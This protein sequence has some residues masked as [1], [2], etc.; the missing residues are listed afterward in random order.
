MILNDY[1]WLS[2]PYQQLASGIIHKRAHH[3]LLINY[4][5]GSG[6]D[7]FVSKLA[8]RL[9]CQYS[10]Q[11]EPCL[12]CHS[13]QLFLSYHH[14]DYYV[15][16]NEQG[17]QS[18]GIDQIRN[19]SSK[20]YEKSQQGGNK[21]LWIK[22]AALMTEAAANA[23]LKTLE[24]PP[25]NTYFILSDDHNSHLL[26]TIHSRCFSY[27]LP[28]PKLEQSIEWLKKQY[29]PQYSD[30]EL[31]SA[32]LLSENAPLKAAALLMP[33]KWQQRKEFCNYLLEVVPQNNYWQLAKTFD[34]EDFIERIIWFCTLLSD[35]L[36]AKQKVGRFIVNRDQV[37]LV[38]L[39]ATN[40]NE[41]LSELYNLWLQARNQLLTITGLNKELIICNV[42]AQSELV[43]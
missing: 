39:L 1:P 26:P 24:E 20:V 33:E 40:S 35:A 34:N 8:S 36:K 42:L 16:T 21:V 25:Q 30:N 23:L 10:Q 17:K 37:P 28:V 11:L 5:Q 22:H 12:K 13:C 38:R 3:A 19:I 2:L 31:A 18:I 4:V 43:D 29:S 6:E 15:I 41:K 27:F 9:L 7:E 32:L 14:P